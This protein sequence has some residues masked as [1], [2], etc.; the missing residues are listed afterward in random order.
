MSLIKFINADYLTFNELVNLKNKEKVIRTAHP[1]NFDPITVF[2]AQYFETLLREDITT[3]A[4][5]YQPEFR[6]SKNSKKLI[7][8]ETPFIGICNL[9][10]IQNKRDQYILAYH[11]KE[12]TKV[13]PNIKKGIDEILKLPQLSEILEIIIKNKPNEFDRY[14]DKKG[15]QYK[16]IESSPI[17]NLYKYKDDF[18]SV[19]N[20]Q[21]LNLYNNHIL[22]LVKSY[23]NSTEKTNYPSIGISNNLFHVILLLNQLNNHS[24]D[25]YHICGNRMYDYLYKDSRFSTI[26]QKN[27]SSLLSIVTKD[28]KVIF[29]FYLIPTT[30]FKNLIKNIQLDFNSQNYFSIYE[31]I[32]IIKQIVQKEKLKTLTQ[33]EVEYKIKVIDILLQNNSCSQYDIVVDGKFKF[34]NMMNEFTDTSFFDLKIINKSCESLLERIKKYKYNI[35]QI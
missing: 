26:N 12:L 32:E 30:Q 2:V 33:S 13:F 1:G 34:F 35:R 20:D 8:S 22:Q 7:A 28:S 6:I 19:K 24:N 9:K 31:L 11:Y 10:E 15:T 17:S 27:I 29:N 5:I 14:Y 23:S 4:E 16:L 25:I 3:G 21:V 18:I